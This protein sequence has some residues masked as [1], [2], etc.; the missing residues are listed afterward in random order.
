MR[1]ARKME[2]PHRP[3]VRN[4]DALDEKIARHGNNHATLVCIS[5]ECDREFISTGFHHRM[6][7]YCRGRE[8]EG[9]I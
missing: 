3:T 1:A 9:L 2:V 8:S 6:C 5:P 4:R 7:D